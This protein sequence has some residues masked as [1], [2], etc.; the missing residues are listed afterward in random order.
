ML[1]VRVGTLVGALAGVALL[2]GGGGSAQAGGLEVDF[3]SIAPSSGFA[4]TPGGCTHIGAS[5]GGYVCS[6]GQTFTASDGDVLTANGYT[7]QFATLTNLTWKNF[8]VA[9]HPPTNSLGESGLGQNTLGPGNACDDPVSNPAVCEVG[10]NRSV[11]V[12][13]SSDPILSVIIGSV[14]DIEQFE[15]FGSTTAGTIPT[16]PISFGG[17]TLFNA[18]NCQNFNSTDTTCTFDLTG[19]NFQVVGLLGQPGVGGAA[20][21]DTLIVGVTVPAPSIGQGLPVVLAIGGMLLGARLFG[22]GRKG[23]GSLRA[24]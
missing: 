7:G 2:F 19:D 10:P 13:S 4:P 9:G 3:G 18:A 24:A 15:L 14:Q 16:I 17:N 1:N 12:S 22:R 8:N 6:S 21:S 5:D 20:P 11:T 23:A